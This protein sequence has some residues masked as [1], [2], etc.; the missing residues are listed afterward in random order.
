MFTQTILP[1]TAQPAYFF[2]HPYTFQAQEIV[3]LKHGN[4]HVMKFFFKFTN[5]HYLLYQAG[6]GKYITHSPM[7]LNWHWKQ[8]LPTIAFLL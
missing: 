7:Q 8:E 2:T 1:I 6:Q 3:S 4:Q 5:V